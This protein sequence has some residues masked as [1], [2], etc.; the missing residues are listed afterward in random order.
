MSVPGTKTPRR[1]SRKGNPPR[2]GAQEDAKSVPPVT[3]RPDSDFPLD[4]IVFIGGTPV[5]YGD[6]SSAGHMAYRIRRA[7]RVWSRS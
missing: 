5:S 4:W 3:V 6:K 1:P 2:K 7:L